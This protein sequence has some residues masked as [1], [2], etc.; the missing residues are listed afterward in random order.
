MDINDLEEMLVILWYINLWVT[1][2]LYQK[3]KKYCDKF[4][5]IKP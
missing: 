3:M 5:N 2:D 1:E 4:F